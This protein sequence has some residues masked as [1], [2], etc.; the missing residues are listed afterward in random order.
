MAVFILSIL[1]EYLLE[2]FKLQCLISK[3]YHKDRNNTISTT[4]TSSS[5][6]SPSSIQTEINLLKQE[7]NALHKRII[8]IKL[9]QHDL[10]SKRIKLLK[11]SHH[12]APT[13]FSLERMNFPS[14]PFLVSSTNQ[15]YSYITMSHTRN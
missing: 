1:L 7:N 2:Y 15:T 12:T 5:S 13:N 9:S 14:F 3:E 4:T 6:K 11:S 10:L 8:N